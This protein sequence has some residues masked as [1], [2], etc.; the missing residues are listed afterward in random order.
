M[1]GRTE[2]EREIILGQI[3]TLSKT[4]N[5]MP[6]PAL[7]N[8]WDCRDAH[9]TF[10]YRDGSRSESKHGQC[11]LVFACHIQRTSEKLVESFLC[12]F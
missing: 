12:T 7:Q 1:T 5:V 2:R 10:E 6:A 8:C 9:T 11:D 3:S 4:G